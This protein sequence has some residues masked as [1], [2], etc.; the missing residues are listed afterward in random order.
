M[1]RNPSI[2]LTDNIQKEISALIETGRF[3]N[4]SEAM[5]AGA[6]LLIDKEAQRSAVIKR[7]EAAVDEALESEK[8]ENFDVN[9]FIARKN[10][11]WQ[12]K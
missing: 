4:M 5:R 2:S 11:Q 9:D 10:K 8:V 1:V 6:R 7:L 12:G 3:Q